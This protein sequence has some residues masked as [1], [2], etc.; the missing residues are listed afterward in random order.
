[1]FESIYVGLTGLT[2]FSRNLTVIGNNVTNVD[3][4]GFKGSR[5]DF[6][7][8]VYNSLVAGGD[9]TRLL[10]GNGVQASESRVLFKQGTLNQTGNATDVAIDGNGFFVL[11]QDGATTY[12]RGGNFQFDANGVLVAASGAHVAALAGGALQDFDI[13]SLRVS[14]PHATSVLH[15]TD[16]LSSGGTSQDVS[17]TLFDAAGG[18]TAVTVHFTNNGATTP[19][20]W[21][22]EVRNSAG[23]AIA[24]GEIRF[25][26][27]GSPAAGFNSM[28]FAFTPSA[29]PAQQVT[30]DFGPAGGFSGATNFSAGTTSTLKLGS[31]DGFG[32]GAL[33]ST[34]FDRDGVLQASYSNG[35]SAQGP[36][37]ALAFF[38][39]PQELT[40]AGGSAFENASGQAVVLGGARVGVFGAIAGQTLEAANVDLGTEFGDLI[41]TQRGYQ[42]SSQV[43]TT[44]NDMIQQLFDIRSK[45]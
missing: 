37:L 10:A 5:L 26:G 7:D 21:L 33:T 44:A 43:I 31:Q 28:S 30:L 16:N 9:G 34:S 27:D 17:A 18:N 6:S 24:N 15:F 22:V 3:S 36:R 8:L 38:G 45:G 2:A 14:P 12:S 4:P 11:R 20:S 39:S 35:Q 13:A 1:M 25:N 42:A 32:P 41:I 29:A 23:S 40:P 19:G